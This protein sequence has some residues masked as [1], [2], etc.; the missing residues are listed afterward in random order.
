MLA[1]MVMIGSCIERLSRAMQICFNRL[2]SDAVFQIKQLGR[3]NDYARRLP[4]ID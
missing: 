2:V 1:T 3:Q 4:L